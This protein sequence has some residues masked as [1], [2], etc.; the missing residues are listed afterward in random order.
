MRSATPRVPW[1]QD[2][3]ARLAH[4]VPPRLLQ[5]LRGDFNRSARCH[6]ANTQERGG[7]GREA[8]ACLSRVFFAD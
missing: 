8:R 3:D 5:Q 2:A 7:A 6:R 4:P 1:G